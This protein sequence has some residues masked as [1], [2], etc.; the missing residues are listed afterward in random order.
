MWECHAQ[1]YSLR[2]FGGLLVAFLVG[3]TRIY[4]SANIAGPASL[5]DRLL[6]QKDGASH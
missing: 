1:I 5:H 6:L 3:T 4:V 2:T